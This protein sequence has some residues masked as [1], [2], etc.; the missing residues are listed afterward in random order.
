[1]AGSVTGAHA[2]RCCGELRLLVWKRWLSM[3]AMS[4]ALTVMNNTAPHSALYSVVFRLMGC[5][6]RLDTVPS[7]PVKGDEPEYELVSI[8]K[9]VYIGNVPQFRCIAIDEQSQT[10]TYHE[11]II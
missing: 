6:H 11:S 5:S 9:D 3:R 2:R 7:A 10:I 8:G 1:M 4:G